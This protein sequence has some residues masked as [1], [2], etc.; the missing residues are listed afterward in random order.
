[1]PCRG[2]PAC[3]PLPA[4]CP[5]ACHVGLSLEHAVLRATPAILVE[6]AA[7]LAMPAVTPAE[8]HTRH[9]YGVSECHPARTPPHS[10]STRRKVEQAARLAMPAVTPA[11]RH[12]PQ[13]Y[14]RSHAIQPARLRAPPQPAP[15]FPSPCSPCSLWFAF[16]VPSMSCPMWGRL[17]S[18]RPAFEPA[19][20]PFIH[21]PLFRPIAA[22]P[23]E[24]AAR[25]AM[26]A[27]T[28]A[29]RH[30][31]QRYGSSHAIQPARLRAPP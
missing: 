24:Q 13:R 9:T 19:W 2:G 30:N 12:N 10:T 7:R 22:A 18:L 6:Q 11:E 17:S 23:V 27:V 5:K 28:P 29:E 14:G 3:P 31:P 25:L 8:Q 20:A 16:S 15:S 26:P 1:M 4:P 21:C